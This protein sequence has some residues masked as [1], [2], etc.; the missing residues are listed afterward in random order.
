MSQT[1]MIDLW[2]TT[3][4][5]LGKKGNAEPSKGSTCGV[6]RP[7]VEPTCDTSSEENV[8]VEH[9]L[10]HPSG[11]PVMVKELWGLVLP[12]LA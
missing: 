12:L 6:T 4:K 11:D 1:A 7:V 5:Y 10:K 8:G 2:V 3:T 9:V